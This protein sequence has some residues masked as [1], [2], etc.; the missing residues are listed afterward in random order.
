MRPFSTTS[1]LCLSVVVTGLALSEIVS[2]PT[3][4]SAEPKPSTVDSVPPR[5]MEKLGRGVVAINQGNGRVFVSWRLLGTDPDGIGFNVYRAVG[6]DPAVKL[7]AEPLTGGTYFLDSAAPPTAVTAY[8]VRPVVSGKELDPSRPFVLPANAK[9]VPY[10]SVPLKTPTGYHAND[11]SV[12]DLD[13][14]GEYEIVVHMVGRG[15]DN[16]QAG[17]TTE[18]ILDAYKLDGTHLWR[19]NLG[20]NIREGAHYTQFM[21]YDLD[22]DGRAEIACKTADGT[23]DGAGKP[24]GDPNADHRNASGY[25]LKGPEFLTVFDG[26]TGRAISTVDYIPSRGN[27]ADWGD[28]KGNRVDRFLACVAYLDGVRPSLVM[29]R[30]YYTRAV[31][32][33]WDFRDGKLNHRWTF[34]SDAGPPE[35]R[36]YRGQGNHGISV[37]S[38]ATARTRSCTGRASST[39]TGPAGTRPATATAT[40]CT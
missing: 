36:K 40:P 31:L 18:P 26:P 28:A 37:T 20:K 7:N 39:A 14:D 24:I 4:T 5:W 25:V 32:A 27:V 34:D 10:L 29:C 38:T 19:I 23:V 30:G 33:A 21:V 6:E 17:T 13:G 9:A 1:V 15:R 12:G 3:P 22:G 2:G 16:S 35:N 8:T 11:A